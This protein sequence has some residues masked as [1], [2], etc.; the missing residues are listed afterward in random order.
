MKD[1]F[2]KAESTT[3]NK[4]TTANEEP[5]TDEKA[6][7]TDDKEHLM[8][9]DFDLDTEKLCSIVWPA[10]VVI[11]GVDRGLRIGGQCTH[12]TFAK[13]GIILGSLKKG[14]TTV[15]V[16]WEYDGM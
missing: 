8:Y 4:T 2:T 16:Q 14:L 9:P 5:K 7:K 3:T 15:K 6:N 13:K 10:L 12:K 11:G 1:L